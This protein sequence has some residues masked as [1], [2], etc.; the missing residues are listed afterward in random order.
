MLTWLLVG[1][2]SW[3]HPP[4]GSGRA[5]AR[6]DWAQWQL[7]RGKQVVTQHFCLGLGV[8]SLF[9]EHT[10]F[11]ETELLKLF[12][13]G[14]CAILPASLGV[15]CESRVDSGC[16]ISWGRGIAHPG[17]LVWCD[18]E[19]GKVSARREESEVGKTQGKIWGKCEAL[20][21]P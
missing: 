19:K 17:L 2:Q 21:V 13:A 1:A 16:I 11:S 12:R 3:V 8:I 4:N 14:A 6:G 15:G 10:L 5:P 20:S 18:V 9:F 7:F